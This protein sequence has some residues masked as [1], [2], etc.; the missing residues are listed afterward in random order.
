MS[1]EQ[2]TPRPRTPRTKATAEKAA[3]KPRAA[4]REAQA[5]GNGGFQ[6]PTY[7]WLRQRYHDEVQP[8]LQR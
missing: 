7:I 4:K 8:A 6:K 1:D 5:G 2:T 3:S